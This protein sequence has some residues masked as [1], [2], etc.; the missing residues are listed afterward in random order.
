MD[1][2]DKLKGKMFFMYDNNQ[3]LITLFDYDYINQ[4]N[5]DFNTSYYV[6]VQI[7]EIYTD[8]VEFILTDEKIGKKEISYYSK[9][10]ILCVHFGYE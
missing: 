8:F 10:R 7:G 6:K 1:F 2:F 9:S 4:N 5:N 3:G